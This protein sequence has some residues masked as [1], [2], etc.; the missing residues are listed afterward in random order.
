MTR[1]EE[2]KL[3][4]RER[5]A[6]LEIKLANRALRRR[7]SWVDERITDVVE[8]MLPEVPGEDHARGGLDRPR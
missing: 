5:R 4:A 6:A 3:L 7:K 8:R 2:L 1:R